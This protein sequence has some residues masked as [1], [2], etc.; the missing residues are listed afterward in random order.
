M[1]WHIFKDRSLLKCLKKI[2]LSS[3]GEIITLQ[4]IPLH[5]VYLMPLICLGWTHLG[6]LSLA[7]NFRVIGKTCVWLREL[8]VSVNRRLTECVLESSHIFTCD[9]AHRFPS[10]IVLQRQKS[11]AWRETPICF[12]GNVDCY[13]GMKSFPWKKAAYNRFYGSLGKDTCPTHFLCCV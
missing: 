5:Y 9:W 2:S 8:E 4:T 6:R 7:R 11:H 1:I 3:R 12:Q 10:G 13:K